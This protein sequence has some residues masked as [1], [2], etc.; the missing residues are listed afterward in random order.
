ML[1]DVARSMTRNLTRPSFFS[2]CCTEVCYDEDARQRGLI[3]TGIDA[4]DE[5]PKMLIEENGTVSYEDALRTLSRRMGTMTE[6]MHEENDDTRN[7][8]VFYQVDPRTSEVVTSETL[9]IHT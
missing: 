2:V 9:T 5:S 4:D 3:P 6:T 1:A 8:R 7:V